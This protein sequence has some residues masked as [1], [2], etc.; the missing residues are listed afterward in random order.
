MG[1]TVL[2]NVIRK[3]EVPCGSC[4]STS[5]DDAIGYGRPILLGNSPS[6][7][8]LSAFTAARP[9]ERLSKRQI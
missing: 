8:P 1:Q 6:V 9:S 5:V 7:C 3:H 2:L 4:V